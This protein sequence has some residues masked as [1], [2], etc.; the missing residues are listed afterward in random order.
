[1]QWQLVL[2]VQTYYDL[3][4][5]LGQEFEDRLNDFDKLKLCV[6]F[7]S[8]PFMEVDASQTAEQMA[9]LFSVNPVELEMEIMI[10]SPI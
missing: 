9:E 2:Y 3:L 10:F 1:M 6:A 5:K 7:I 4:S 8:N